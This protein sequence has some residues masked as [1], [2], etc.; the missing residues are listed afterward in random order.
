MDREKKKEFSNPSPHFEGFYIFNALFLAES[1]HQNSCFLIFETWWDRETFISDQF[2]I[3]QEGVFNY[4]PYNKY[5]YEYTLQ[6]N[7]NDL[8]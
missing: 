3:F 8:N 2:L 1:L 4:Q 7:K 6:I 5:R